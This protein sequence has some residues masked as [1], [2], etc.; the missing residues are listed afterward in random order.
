M[1]HSLLT[2]SAFDEKS[3]VIN[4]MSPLYVVCY[5]ALAAFNIFSLPFVFSSL[6]IICLAVVF[7]VFILF[8]VHIELPKSI[9]SCL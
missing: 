4:I 6:I 3:S 7:L 1:F 8:V 9:I 5:F 2:F